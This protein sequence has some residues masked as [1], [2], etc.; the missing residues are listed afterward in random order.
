MSLHALTD[1]H[2]LGNPFHQR[3]KSADEFIRCIIWADW[4]PSAAFDS[5]SKNL[6]GIKPQLIRDSLR[7]LRE[8]PDL[9]RY[10]HAL[11]RIVELADDDD[12]LRESWKR[13]L[14]HLRALLYTSPI[15]TERQRSKLSEVAQNQQVVSAMR[16]ALGQE[17]E[18]V[19][20]RI[21][22]TWIAVLYAEGSD[23]CVREADRFNALL[24]PGLG[25]RLREYK[26]KAV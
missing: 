20:R 21:E 3:P 13:N 25:A 4:D 16:Y 18:P 17:A 14:S 19:P 15:G 9:S 7:L 8:R 12:A 10:T 1:M 11:T 23:A 6:V 5:G 24:E 2:P 22:P 26:A